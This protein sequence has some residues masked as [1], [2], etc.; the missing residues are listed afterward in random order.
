MVNSIF[1]INTLHL[2]TNRWLQCIMDRALQEEIHHSSIARFLTIRGINPWSPRLILKQIG[3]KKC[4]CIERILISQVVTHRYLSSQL[5]TNN[6]QIA[7][8]INNKNQWQ[9]M[10]RSITIKIKI[11]IPWAETCMKKNKRRKVELIQAST[12][13][14]LGI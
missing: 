10:I 7:H 11:K 4:T 2:T 6:H 12:L 1:Q 9:M 13:K 8:K 14:Y 3:N 5:R